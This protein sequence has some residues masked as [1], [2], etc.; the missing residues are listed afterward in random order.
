[1]QNKANLAEEEIDVNG[2]SARDYIK[3]SEFRGRKNKANFVVS[4]LRTQST[5]RFLMLMSADVGE[6]QT[7][8]LCV[9]GDLRGKKKMKKQ[10]QF[11]LLA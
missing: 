11:K 7:H 6:L 9:L 2:L 3:M 4:P 8:F 10:S 1:M 5:Q